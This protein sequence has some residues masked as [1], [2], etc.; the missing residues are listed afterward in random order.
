MGTKLDIKNKWDK[1]SRDEIKNKNKS[2]KWLKNK[3][4]QQSEEREP[5]SI[6][7]QTSMTRFVF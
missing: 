4:K 6:Q 5:K 7:I 3:K 1:I 2:R